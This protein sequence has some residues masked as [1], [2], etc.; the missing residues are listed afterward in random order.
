MNAERLN[1][2]LNDKTIS[3]L[4]DFLQNALSVFAGD[5]IESHGE[6]SEALAW[7]RGSDG[8]FHKQNPIPRIRLPFLSNE[9]LKEVPGYDFCVKYFDEDELIR[10]HLRT[11]VGIPGMASRID[12]ER[13]LWYMISSMIDES[14]K[15]V[16][17]AFETQIEKLR[18]FCSS[19][20]LNY[21]VICPIPYLKSDTF[22]LRLSDETV[23]DYLT[24]D[25]TRYCIAVGVLQP[26]SPSHPIVESSLAVGIRNT[27]KLPKIIRGHSKKLA[28]GN[29]EGEFGRRTN[30]RPDLIAEDVLSTFRLVK[31]ARLYCAGFVGISDE[32]FME[33]GV[34]SRRTG[35]ISSGEI[36]EM[37][38]DDANQLKVLWDQLCSNKNEVGFAVQR[39]NLAF[40]RD[41][42]DDRLVDLIICAE[43]LFLGDEQGELSFR[44][45]LRAGQFVEHPVY[46][47]REVF[48]I[49]YDAYGVRS[50][51]VHGSK[52]SRKK[53][54]IRLPGKEDVDLNEF[55][56]NIEDILR[57]GLHKALSMDSK[58]EHRN[59]AFWEELMFSI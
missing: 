6:W 45:A 52:R 17:S 43:S 3:A 26:N 39:F 22:P 31:R 41:H 21:S 50:K 49:M 37:T 9:R 53:S 56:D 29:T 10:P 25:E 55:A 38:S 51:I 5:V 12:E 16:E 44:C 28:V 13:I 36:C 23:L 15:F 30:Y 2:Q 18:R 19:E 40:E 14:T 57:L 35:R 4:R 1:S 58:S 32:P 20:T 42:L 24:D 34:S 27:L 46:S 47:Q 8:Y 59:S 33:F 11:L 7:T 54:K 48:R